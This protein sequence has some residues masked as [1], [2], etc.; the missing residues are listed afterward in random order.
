MQATTTD[1][2]ITAHL[3]RRAGFGARRDELEAYAAKGYE[4][5]VDDLL[6]PE[7]FPE[8]EEDVLERYY[9]TKGGP[10]GR[11]YHRMVNTE[12]PLQEK[13]VVFW[14][15]VFPTSQSKSGHSVSA[16]EQIAMFR[17][18]CLTDMR[19]ILTELSKDPAMIFWLDNNENF[20]DAPNENY[21]RELLEL[22]S[23]GVGNYTE[24]DVKGA[25]RAFSGWSFLTP[26]PG[27][28]NDRFPSEFEFHGQDHDQDGK[29]FLGESGPF[30]GEDIIDVIVKQPATA[31]FV[32]RQLYTFFVAD[33]PAVASWNEFPPQDAE[34]I[35]TL[36]RAYFESGGQIRPML[37]TLFMSDFFKE[38][39]FKRVKSP[40]EAVLGIIK[41]TG[42]CR[43]P[44]LANGS[45]FGAF[46]GMGQSLLGPISVEGWRTGVEWIDGGRLNRRVD[47][48]TEEVEDRSAPGI[49]DMIDRLDAQSPLSPEEF[50]D[51]CLDLAGPVVVGA[52]T[53]DALV[54][55]AESGGPL[56]FSNGIG[57]DENEAR[58]VRMLQLILSTREYQ[59]G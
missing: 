52:E 53:R 11:W 26:A 28:G 9:S 54:K 59:F 56:D 7:R 30:N 16:Q 27:V 31:R 55:Q 17:R 29:S 41:L 37:R 8:V 5:A 46:S 50:V 45:H 48:A 51:T 42:T 20:S 34:A 22:F 47:F 39:E 10:S 58:V 23:M 12:R 15:M 36:V 32:A 44:T 6:N 38:A 3:L 1:L 21:G 19:T 35:D 4:Q 57:R 18:V 14:H 33:E 43:V 49:R 40:V 13:M 24:E 2:S 25:T